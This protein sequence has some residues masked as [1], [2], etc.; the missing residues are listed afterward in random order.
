M[1][2][3]SLLPANSEVEKGR[4]LRTRGP[5]PPLLPTGEERAGERRGLTYSF[6][7]I[8]GRWFNHFPQSP[9]ARSARLAFAPFGAA[10]GRALR[11]AAR[12][13]PDKGRALACGRKHRTMVRGTVRV[14]CARIAA[15]RWRTDR[16]R[17]ARRAVVPRS[18]G[19]GPRSVRPSGERAGDER[20]PTCP[21]CPACPSYPGYPAPSRT[22]FD[23]FARD[24]RAGLNDFPQ[25]PGAH[26]VR[27]ATRQRRGAQS[28]APG[29]TAARSPVFDCPS[30]AA[31]SAP[32]PRRNRR[33][34]GLY[35]DRAAKQSGRRKCAARREA[36][37][38]ASGASARRLREKKEEGS[39]RSYAGRLPPFRACPRGARSLSQRA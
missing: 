29:R 31:D 25:A 24:G 5:I 26:S 37:R 1:A 36:R 8:A 6:P 11:A 13:G 4:R 12:P 23:C 14:A 30:V 16:V 18:S 34:V 10:R 22:I 7:S 21:T 17:L 39:A 32:A 33:G 3:A 19:C 15:C 38:Q 2:S 35:R 9:G 28:R 27:L 20:D